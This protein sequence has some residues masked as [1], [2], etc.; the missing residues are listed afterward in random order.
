MK[1]ILCMG[2]LLGFFSAN[3]FAEAK[4]KANAS[5]G[6]AKAAVC[7]SCHGSNGMTTIPGYPNLAGQNEQY[8][9]TAMKA[10]KSG[11]RTGATATIMKLQMQVLNEQDIK[12]LAAY[13]SQ[14]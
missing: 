5:A 9:V 11:E 3:A 13:Y 7:A 2:L 6:K 8:L 4:V 12:D 14:M 1:K 10:Y